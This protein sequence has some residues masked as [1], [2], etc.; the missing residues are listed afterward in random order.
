[1]SSVTSP[2]VT[3]DNKAKATLARDQPDADNQEV[4]TDHFE[5]DQPGLHRQ[6]RRANQ[7]QTIKK[8]HG[9][10]QAAEASGAAAGAA[11]RATSAA[12]EQSKK[13]SKAASKQQSSKQAKAQQVRK[14]VA[15]SKRSEAK[16]SSKAAR[17]LQAAK[18][19]ASK[20]A[21]KACTGTL[22]PALTHFSLHALA[23]FNMR[24][25]CTG[26]LQPV[27]TRSHFSLVT[28]EGLGVSTHRAMT[29]RIRNGWASF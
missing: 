5:K 17:E 27:L 15:S 12:Q 11:S 25:A 13:A 10:E 14:Q 1:M 7:T 22:Q 18:D 21:S 9:H 28:S 19:Q 29:R 24:P 4:P 2:L 6:S 16:Q 20:A 3:L 23:H 8:G 26:T